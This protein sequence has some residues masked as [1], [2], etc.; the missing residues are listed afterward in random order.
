M[1]TII[2]LA[3]LLVFATAAFG[4]PK[5]MSI[6]KF[7]LIIIIF[8]GCK[9]ENKQDLTTIKV[10]ES[11]TNLAVRGAT[12]ALFKCDYGCPFGANILFKGDTDENGTCQVAAESYNDASSVV[13]V[14]KIKYWPFLVKKSTTLS[15]TPEGWLQLRIH[16]AGNYPVGSKLLLNL[17]DQSDR[18]DLTQYN[19]AADGLILVKAF[20]GQQNKINWQV[21][22]V[23]FNLLN[24]GTLNG[25]QIP[26][27]DTLK[28]ITLNY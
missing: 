24:N 12:V 3:L 8:S 13:N 21:V 16:K 2:S 1:E 28:N 25:L 27:F 23:N 10:V 20:G 19:T 14:V 17:F 6:K 26:R 4:Q 18:S 9:K 7:Y 22:D 11:I 15:I 5:E